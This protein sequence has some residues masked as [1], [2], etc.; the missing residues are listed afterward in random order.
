MTALWLAAVLLPAQTS[1]SQPPDSEQPTVRTS[2]TVVEHI[3]AETP[4]NVTTLD[5]LQIERIPGDN[6]D[7]RLRS[8]PGFSLFRRTSSVVA[9]PT[10][11][12]L[13][14]RGIGSSGA[15]R[16]L[17]L[18]DGVPMNDPF[19]GWV[20]W[21]RFTPAEMSR[22]EVSRGAA[23]SVFGDLAM[24]GSL[25]LFAE[26]PVKNRFGAGYEGGN[27]NTHDVWGDFTR[28]WNNIAVSASS[29]AY[30]TEGYYVVAGPIRGAIDREAGVRFA[31]GT[32][33]IDS[34]AGPQRLYGEI[35]VLAEERANGTYITH[36]STGLGTASLHYLYQF[37][38]DGIS[39]I[40]FLTKDQY[41]ATFSSISN[42][43]NTER[44]VSTQTVPSEG[45][46]GSAIYNHSAEWW[47]VVAGA[48]INHEHG[49]S[50][51]HFP[52]KI[53]TI[54]TAGGTLFEHGVFVQADAHIGALRVFGGGRQETAAHRNYF[55][56]SGGLVV[57]S[58]RWRARGTVYRSFRTPSLNELYR[59]FRA[60]NTLTLSNA[61]LQ[62][63]TLFGGEIGADFLGESSS[64]RVTAFHNTLDRLITNVTLSS[65]KSL[66]TRQ[67]QN[68]ASA[69]AEGVEIET[70]KQWRSLTGEASYLYVSS[71]YVTGP[72]VAQVPRHQGSAQLSYQHIRTTLSAG[73]RA[74]SY[75][76]DDDLNNFKLP[77]YA[78]VQLMGRQQLTASLSG[79][80]S[81]E[82]LLDHQFLTGF[83]PT[84]TIGTPRLWRLG[85]LWRR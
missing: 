55:N 24:S 61:A 13:S 19:G 48:D 27:H 46:G 77:G 30:S 45:D 25:A 1:S 23:T 56:P 11:Q 65:T 75:Q 71:R 32:V 64:V 49:F 22:V 72:Y 26:E 82:N 41:H 79:V 43:R 8:I 54:H 18:F 58:S 57:G 33:R 47:N 60:G 78:S 59:D 67:R 31:T 6:L 10:T 7:D 62:P 12:G 44:L 15:S 3:A 20:Y 21:T 42:S 14:L 84:P 39:L 37:P 66:I 4:A 34:F 40:A 69:T 38:H 81:I 74:Y 5:A 80:A 9:N 2:V 73:V 51:D 85:L 70:R 83:T 28:L 29:R 36:N 68:A 53:P 50:T 76:F 16:T 63:E 52:T 35:N 17:V